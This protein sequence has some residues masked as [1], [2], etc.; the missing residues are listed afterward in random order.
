MF[1]SLKSVGLGI[2]NRWINF[3]KSYIKNHQISNNIYRN[4][5]LR[6]IR[7]QSTN[8]KFTADNLFTS[9]LE[10]LENHINKEFLE[11]DNIKTLDNNKIIDFYNSIENFQREIYD[12]NQLSPNDNIFIIKSN[13]LLN[14]LLN[15][16]K[17]NFNDEL[18]R[19]L[20]I[21]QPLFPTLKTI[22][23]AYYSKNSSNH[24]DSNI[25]MIPFRKL[26]WDAQFQHALDYVEL[27]NGNERYIE[28]K[29]KSLFNVLKYFGG[30]LVGLIACIHGSISVFFPELIEAG[31]GGTSFGIYGIYACIITY[32]VNC[33]FLAGLA[34]SSK[35][36]EN[37]NLMFKQSTMPHDW[38][39]KVD[40]L[41]MCSKI[42]EADSE[43]NGIDGFATRDV[44][45]RVQQMGFE[46]NEPEQE[47]MLRQ[48]WYSSGEGFM[49]VE[50]DIDPAE[51]EWWKHLDNIGVK[52]VWDQDLNKIEQAD[53]TEE[54]NENENENESDDNDNDAELL[55]PSDKKD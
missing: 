53:A 36:L 52:K 43:I 42:V 13:E 31:T 41:K 14:E 17:T 33:G 19:K 47:V 39:L 5:I 18:L 50:P 21:K 44:V 20:F 37:G 28:Y 6:S 12:Y 2:G 16:S 46:V 11:I 48:Y 34:F 9:R 24:I 49:W 7:Y 32:F 22:I 23:N 1:P 51:I 38:Y 54:I 55:L 35:G 4:G 30:S 3:S 45:K 29:K 27:T 26:I 15:D 25:A 10:S 40:Q 8:T